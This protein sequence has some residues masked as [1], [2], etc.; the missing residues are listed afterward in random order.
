VTGTSQAARGGEVTIQGSCLC[1]AV[2]YE[3][4]APLGRT[5][6]CH[7]SIC[8][9]AHGA[10]FATWAG[11]DPEQFR[12]TAGAELVAGF[13]SSPGRERCFCRQCGSPLA[14]THG[15]RVHEIVVGSI[16]GD[17][18][19]RAREHIFVASKAPWYEINDAL[20]QA[21]EWPS[22]LEH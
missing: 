10:A 1:Q 18:G 19:I 14:A 12:W 16:D 4:G 20:P 7:C 3:V 9:K 8:R 21:A 5:G 2:R 22:D 13:A 6:H 15:G 11:V 17:P